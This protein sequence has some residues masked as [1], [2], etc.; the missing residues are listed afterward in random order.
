[1]SAKPVIDAPYIPP[2]F[3]QL[4]YELNET[5]SQADNGDF[6]WFKVSKLRLRVFEAIEESSTFQKI[7]PTNDKVSSI[8]K[9]VWHTCM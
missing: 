5:F 7:T 3:S 1:M 6:T 9:A 2:P 8:V 4:L